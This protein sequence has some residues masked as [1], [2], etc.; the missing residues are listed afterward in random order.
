[1][2]KKETENKPTK[3]W[4]TVDS[5][6]WGGGAL[7]SVAAALLHLAAGLAVAGLFCLVGAWLID[8]SGG[9]GEAK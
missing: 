9:G 6:F 7:L 1:M 4:T 3:R 5:L 2:E 8:R